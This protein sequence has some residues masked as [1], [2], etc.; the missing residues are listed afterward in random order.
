M[1]GLA[2]IYGNSNRGEV[3]A[4]MQTIIYRGPYASGIYEGDRVILAQNYLKADGV[5]SS[6][7]T[8]KAEYGFA[9]ET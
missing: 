4:I 1:S 9:V 8:T 5:V 6:N 3:E 7:G 2:V